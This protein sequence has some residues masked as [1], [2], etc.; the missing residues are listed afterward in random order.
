MQQQLR[1]KKTRTIREVKCVTKSSSPYTTSPLLWKHIRFN[2][3]HKTGVHT[4]RFEFIP[5]QWQ[6]LQQL[7][8]Q[9]CQFQTSCSNPSTSP[10]SFG[11]EIK[12]PNIGCCDTGVETTAQSSFIQGVTYRNIAQVQYYQVHHNEKY[13]PRTSFVGK[14]LDDS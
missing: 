6:P 14:N 3:G 13:H 2:Q 1:N 4:L 5:A 11:T 7:R 12:Q 10:Q 8:P 9:G